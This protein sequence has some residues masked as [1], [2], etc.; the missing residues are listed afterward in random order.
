MQNEVIALIDE[1]KN[2]SSYISDL[3]HER[4]YKEASLPMEESAKNFIQL[5][6]IL[7]KEVWN[8]EINGLT[9]LKTFTYKPLNIEERIQFV[10]THSHQYHS[11]IHL[12]E[13]YK[14]AEKLYAKVEILEK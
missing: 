6:F 1:W 9:R 7:N 14:E 13:L 8:S 11:Y 12:N 10:L 4:K 3:F 5:L 2:K